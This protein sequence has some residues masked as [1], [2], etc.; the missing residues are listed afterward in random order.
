MRVLVV[1]ALALAATGCG[2]LD[3]PGPPIP[4]GPDPAV[5]GPRKAVA[6]ERP[7]I[8][9]PPLQE[10]SRR[11]ARALESGAVGIVDVTG[12]VRIRPSV[13][14]TASNARVEELEWTRWSRSGAEG[15]GSLRSLVCKTTCARATAEMIPATITLSGVR[16][17]D[18]RRYFEAGAVEIDLARTP[19]GEQPATYLRAPC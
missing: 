17:C 15:R 16:E 1:A 12:T 10:P 19:A 9:I 8:A 11:V 5:Y 2:V 14:E 18:G 6:R 7:P 13:L 3:D 4:T